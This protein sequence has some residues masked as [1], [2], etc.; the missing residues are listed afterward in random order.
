MSRHFITGATGFIGGALVL[1]LLKRT[2]AEIICLVRSTPKF[3]D[4]SQR[5]YNALTHAAIV[6]G[7]QSLIPEIFARCTPC[8]GSILEANCGVSSPKQYKIDEVWHSAA[9]LKYKN[10]NA[11]EVFD[12]NVHGTCNVLALAQAAGGKVLN[13][14]STAYVAGKRSGLISEE[15]QTSDEV[16]NNEY[17]R[18]KIHAEWIVAENKSMHI[19]ILRPSILIGHSRTYAATSFTGLYGFLRELYMFKRRFSGMPQGPDKHP[20]SIRAKATGAINLMP[21]DALVSNAVAVSQSNSSKQIFH[22]TNAEPPA[23]EPCAVALFDLLGL[24]KPKLITNSEHLSEFDC[25]LE[26]GIGFY[27]SYL[28]DSKVFCQRNAAEVIPLAAR[29]HPLGD[30]ALRKYIGWYL[31][32]L[33]EGCRGARIEPDPVLYGSTVSH[34]PLETALLQ[35]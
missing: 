11:L 7:E 33:E 6:Y 13:Y 31:A 27:S 32:R 28:G 25:Y 4:A 26:R 2:D 9:S 24:P 3:E 21:V 18:S 8:Q 20:L 23:I 30:Q 29:R 5:L 10:A 34:S 35:G 15:L 17:E 12:H 14:I 16:A 19:R 1:E 22:L